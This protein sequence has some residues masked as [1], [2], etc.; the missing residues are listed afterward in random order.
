MPPR[1]PATDPTRMHEPMSTET[2]PHE[3]ETTGP[4]T[5][6][7][8]DFLKV[9]R[10]YSRLPAPRFAFESEPHALPDFSRAAWAIPL[11]GTII[12]AVGAGIGLLA[13][14]AGLSTLIAAVLTV[15]TLVVVTGAFHEDGLADT[16]DGLWG[17]ATPE[18]RL[19][20]MKDSRIGT[21]GAAGLTL[22]L[23]LR[24]FALTEMFR[25]IGPYALLLVIGV[26][27]ASRPLALIPVLILPPARSE[28]LAA[29]VPLPGPATLAVSIGLGLAILAA[30][31]WR[32]DMLAPT[33]TGLIALIGVMA[34]LVRIADRKIGGHT[35]D[36]LGAAQ[37]AAEITLL[38]TFSAALNWSGPV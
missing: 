23:A 6:L 7:A 21:F 33:A 14:L 5:H 11:V 24:V 26:A 31:V 17:G 8:G 25:L 22:S 36:I 20:I 3:P 15:A 18:R 1:D 13:Y 34:A 35:G 10:F 12:G 4:A 38:M 19:E 16:C 37:Q 29:G 9:M 28:G 2:P 27:A 30:S 32:N